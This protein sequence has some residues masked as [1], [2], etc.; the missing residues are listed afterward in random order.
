MADVGQIEQSL[1]NLVTNAR[2]AMPDGGNLK[3]RTEVMEMDDAFIKLHGYGIAGR[4]VHIAVSDTGMGMDENTK[5]RVFDPFFTTKEV[6]KGTGL[7]LASVYGI[8]KQHSGYIAVDSEP[9]K[10]ATFNIYLPVIESE[11]EQEER[12]DSKI[13]TPFS[14][15]GT[16]TVL[17]AEDDPEVREIVRTVF[18]RAGYRVIEAADGE[19][20]IVKFMEH[21]DSIKLLVSDLIMPK[22]NG[23]EVYEAIRK[24]MPDMKAL[25][26]TGYD[27]NVIGKIDI[28]KGKFGYLTKPVSPVELLRK[29]RELLDK[30]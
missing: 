22:K 14:E 27:D 20:A 19:D 13:H 18:E 9:G 26:V 30:S 12:E 5:L 21:K 24:V 3:I 8:V 15:G 29:V 7:G 25:F 17:L 28:Q 16:E 11:A 2:D 1:M 23:K 10:G 4:Y 6:G